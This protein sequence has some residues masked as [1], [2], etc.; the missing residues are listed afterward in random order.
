[1]LGRQEILIIL[2][3][4]MK[5]DPHQPACYLTTIVYYDISTDFF[6]AK[7]RTASKQQQELTEERRI[8]SD[9]EN[10]QSSRFTGTA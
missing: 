6:W 2:V 4:M 10:K 1:M 3:R 5:C 9:D 7:W 8:K